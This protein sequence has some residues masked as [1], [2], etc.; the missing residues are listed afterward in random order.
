MTW[1]RWCKLAF[2]HLSDPDYGWDLYSSLMWID[3][4]RCYEV[5]NNYPMASGRAVEPDETV[6]PPPPPDTPRG[7]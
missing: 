2:L 3:D 1:C 5:A 6:L 7:R 4:R